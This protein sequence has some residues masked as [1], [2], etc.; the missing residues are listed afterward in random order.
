Q[1]Q[2]VRAMVH[3]MTTY[4]LGR[5]LTFADHS[6]VDTITADVRKQGDGL[7]TMIQLVITSELF[8]SR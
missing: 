2:F 6:S 8:Q 7:S 5:P 4:A 3:K 1:D